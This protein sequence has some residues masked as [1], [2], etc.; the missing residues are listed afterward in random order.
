MLGHALELAFFIAGFWSMSFGAR[1][2]SRVSPGSDLY[3]FRVW[4]RPG[5]REE[6]TPEGWRYRKLALL[7]QGIALLIA[8]LW[9]ALGTAED[10]RASKFS[11]LLITRGAQPL[12]TSVSN[13]AGEGPGVRACDAGDPDLV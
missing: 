9:L 10:Q 2:M 6:F 1:A 3:R 11:L 5:R 12:S 4:P 7:C 8:T 13:T